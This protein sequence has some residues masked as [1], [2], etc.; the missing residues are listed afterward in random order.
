MN[1]YR[2]GIPG[3]GSSGGRPSPEPRNTH[4][5][6]DH[7]RIVH[8][9]AYS[10]SADGPVV[11]DEFSGSEWYFGSVRFVRDDDGA[12]VAMLV[13]SGRVRNVR[14]ERERN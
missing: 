5:D 8:G 7:E 2:T 14:F 11:T 1:N 3:R 6:D 4:F 13:S 9:R 10:Y 12:I